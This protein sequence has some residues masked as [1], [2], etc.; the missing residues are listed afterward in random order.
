MQK[1]IIIDTTTITEESMKQELAMAAKQQERDQQQRSW[2]SQEFLKEP[3]KR[4]DFIKIVNT[5]EFLDQNLKHIQKDDALDEKWSP[6][7]K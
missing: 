5:L 2:I 1:I 6:Y 4:N 3:Q 7:V